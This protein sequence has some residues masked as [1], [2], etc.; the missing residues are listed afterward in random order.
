MIIELKYTKNLEISDNKNILVQEL[1]LL[2][3]SSLE[4]PSTTHLDLVGA[5]TDLK[6][7]NKIFI[8]CVPPHAIFNVKINI[9]IQNS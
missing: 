7:E 8:G 3:S 9:D 4:W 6:V 1:K 2:N 5:L